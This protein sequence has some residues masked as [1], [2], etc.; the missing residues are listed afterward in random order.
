VV[1]AVALLVGGGIAVWR[2]LQGSEHFVLRDLAV[3]GAR[4]LPS[5]EVGAL[6]GVAVNRTD[7]LTASTDDIR[8]TC[9]ADPRIRRAS[10]AIEPPGRMEIAIEEQAPA[11]FAAFDGGLWAVNELGEAYA[12]ASPLDWTGLPLLVGVGP[13]STADDERGADVLREA[14]A[15]VRTVATPGSP[16]AGASLLVEFDPDLGFGLSAAGVGL[17]AR[18]GEP[19]FV[20]KYERL[21]EA[22]DVAATQ[23][24]VVREAFVD[25]LARPNAVTLRIAL[26]GPVAAGSARPSGEDRQ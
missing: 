12:P 5:A 8:A 13:R 11:M 24:L 20:R 10:V 4:T 1:A 2:A 22:L 21:V 15:L 25:N 14:L 16:W 18:F 19:P 17:R 7:L 26:S 6:C 23:R 9:E 3:T